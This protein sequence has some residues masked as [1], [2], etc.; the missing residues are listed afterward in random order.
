MKLSAFILCFVLC[1]SGTTQNFNNSYD[2]K[3]VSQVAWD[4]EIKDTNY[5]LFCGSLD[6]NNN[7]IGVYVLELTSSGIPIS[8]NFLFNP[9]AQIAVGWANSTNPTRDG[10]Y[11]MGGGIDDGVDYGYLVKFNAQGDTV[12][13]KRHGANGFFDTFR[14]ARQC[15]DGGF[16][17]VG[18]SNQR[19][20]QLSDPWLVRTDSNGNFLWQKFYG[21]VN[22]L[23][24]FSSVFQTTDG[25]LI[26][27]GILR[28]D[29]VASNRNTDP[30]IYKVDSLG[31]VQ[32]SYWHDTPYDDVSAHAIQTMD[33]NYVFSASISV[34]KGSSAYSH[35]AL[36]KLDPAGNLMW[37]KKYGPTGSNTGLMMVKELPDSSLIAVGRIG[38]GITSKA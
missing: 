3:N 4:I 19:N 16:V 21:D 5:V 26:M 13:T 33:G 28:D 11:I 38:L 20:G 18:E 37:V 24:R 30:I 8:S 14:Q 34:T 31:L 9:T 23:E 6:S 7:R 35:P 27:G 22:K 1:H 2:W 12:W 36:F 32:W 25:G 29:R 15:K 17:A 10:G